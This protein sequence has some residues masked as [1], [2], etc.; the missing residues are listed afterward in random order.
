MSPDRWTYSAMIK[1][2][3]QANQREQAQLLLNEAIESMVFSVDIAL[4]GK[5]SQR[6]E[7][8]LDKISQEASELIL[9][10]LIDSMRKMHPAQQFPI[11]VS[12][13]AT[14]KPHFTDA[15]V[16]YQKLQQD[17]LLEVK[18]V[19]INAVLHTIHIEFL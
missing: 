6:G 7:L 4:T 15:N 10:R 3:V 11:T 9:E 5:G 1:G 13:H 19:R 18:L 12:I 8:N 2:Y 14:G 16:I 17:E